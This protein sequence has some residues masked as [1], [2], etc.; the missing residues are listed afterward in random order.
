MNSMPTVSRIDIGICILLGVLLWLPGQ[1][2]AWPFQEDLPAAKEVLDDYIQAKG[3]AENHRQIQTI[4]SRGTIAIPQS[5]MRGTLEIYQMAPSKMFM[6]MNFEGQGKS[7]SVFNGKH[8]WVKQTN[9]GQDGQLEEPTYTMLSGERLAQFKVQSNLNL[10]MEVLEIFDSVT[11]TGVEEFN[12]EACYELVAESPN[13][14]TIKAYFSKESKLLV[15]SQNPRAQENG[16]QEV[17]QQQVVS[18]LSRYRAVG[19]IKMSHKAVSVF[20]GLT[21]IIVMK[22]IQLDAE[23]PADIFDLPTELEAA[24]AKLDN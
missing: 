5:N 7:V 10:Y 4:V 20:D 17:E 6:E 13:I 24:A 8:G 23:I 3:G 9:V 15:G 16:Q 19:E 21:Q 1:A 12:G 11:C 14:P 18:R 2:D 22:E